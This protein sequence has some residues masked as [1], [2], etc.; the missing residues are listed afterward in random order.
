M[1]EK[2]IPIA[3]SKTTLMLTAFHDWEYW[4]KAS[5]LLVFLFECDF[6]SALWIDYV[7]FDYYDN[8]SHYDASIWY[9]VVDVLGPDYVFALGFSFCKNVKFE[10]SKQLK[11]IEITIVSMWT[12]KLHAYSIAH[13]HSHVLHRAHFC[14]TQCTCS[15][16]TVNISFLTVMSFVIYHTCV[17]ALVH[18]VPWVRS[19][20]KEM[21]TCHSL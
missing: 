4:W 5:I 10:M 2:K 20:G 13:I 3:Y 8:H 16:H 6:V 19:Y 17:C 18:I 14:A 11:C 21:K 9:C 12:S 1:Y 7:S 15:C